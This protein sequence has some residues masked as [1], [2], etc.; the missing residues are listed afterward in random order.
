M[1]FLHASLG[2][3]ERPQMKI[4][5][6]PSLD[7]F[8]WPLHVCVLVAQSYLTLCDPMNY[9]LPVSSIHGILQARILEWVAIPS[10]GDLPDPG[11]KPGAPTS[12]A[13][14]LPSE[15]AENPFSICIHLLFFLYSM[16]KE[17]SLF[18]SKTSSF[19]I[20][21]STQSHC[22]SP[23]AFLYIILS[24]FMMAQRQANTDLKAVPIQHA[25]SNLFP[26]HKRIV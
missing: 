14:S 19:L 21:V 13:D 9:S 8:Y 16:L 20:Q 15:P 6:F 17:V 24:H 2:R 22:C 1:T 23:S 5:T 12:Q 18:L 26:F 7:L 10:L 3:K 4:F 11:I 25:I